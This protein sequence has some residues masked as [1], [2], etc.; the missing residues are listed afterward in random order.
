M[1]IN[2]LDR[3]LKRVIRK[4]DIPGA[5]VAVLRRN[6]I[7]ACAG[8]G[9]TSVETGVPVT[10]DTLF[11]I[12]SITK[13]M[14][15][16]MIMQLRDEG[17]L[18]LDDLLLDHLPG[19]RIADMKRLKSVTLRH[20]LSHSSGIDGD[21]FPPTDIG[22]RSIEQLL[23]MCAM[24]PS[25]FEPGTNFS[26]CN[27]GFSAL[28]RII[29]VLDNRSW[30]ESLKARIFKPLDMNQALSSPIDLIRFS[31]AVGHVS[32]QPG[33]PLRVPVNPFLSVGHKAAGSMP[34]MTPTDLLKFAVAHLHDGVAVN[35]YQLLRKRSAA[36]M[37]RPQLPRAVSRTRG[38]LRIG[39]GW[40]V[41]EVGG[42]RVFSHDG[43]TVGQ[44][45]CLI[46]VPEKQLAIAGVANGGNMSGFFNEI[47][48]GLLRE[49]LRTGPPAAPEPGRIRLRPEELVGN[50]EN[51]VSRVEVNQDEGGVIHC[52]VLARA[53]PGGEGVTNPLTFV[54]GRVATFP[55]GMIEFGGKTGAPAPWIRLGMRLLTRRNGV[56]V[57]FTNS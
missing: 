32:D 6:R 7:V 45:A 47:V 23:D 4:F 33:G 29:E 55:S 51:I 9:V 28:G 1:L 49:T 14:T 20:L 15:A 34:A 40:F 27:V 26:Y 5:S 3:Q 41:G 22:A 13:P 46:V 10:T 53:G 30:D 35:E 16:T 54:Q 21:Y 18:A 50:Y 25:L 36:Q 19:F 43:G 11:Q 44:A 38:A 57:E 8:A 52:K 12:G 17:R 56:G 37:Q 39:L 48:Q 2:Q 42:H 24:L 31:V